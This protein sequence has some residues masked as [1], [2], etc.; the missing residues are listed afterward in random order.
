VA[1]DE[2]IAVA[3]WQS[4]YDDPSL[5]NR[6]LV[7]GFNRALVNEIA[8]RW[9]VSVEEV[10]SGGGEAGAA[11]V[12]GRQADMAV[13][14]L[15]RR[16]LAEGAD[17]SLGYLRRGLRLARL[18]D[19]EIE[20]AGDLESRR[21]AVL[22][23]VEAAAAITSESAN[24]AVES[25]ST[26]RQLLQKL[27]DGSVDAVIADEFTL[28]LMAREDPN[29]VVM[30]ELFA[31]VTYVI[32]V[33]RF[34]A[35]FLALVNFTLQ[36]MHADGTLAR[37]VEQYF[38]PYAPAEDAAGPPDVEVWPGSGAYLGLSPGPGG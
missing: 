32:A 37:L 25:A 24:V 19:T 4:S 14:V 17:Y 22:G 11:S 21:V 30:P 38:G 27:Q 3:G 13:G 7:D 5:D 35:D 36:D 2:A 15:P 28:G 18:T 8:R 33:P 9:G 10:E 16:E 23:P 34:D 12:G 20:G 31:P 1:R 6:R 29:V 26:P